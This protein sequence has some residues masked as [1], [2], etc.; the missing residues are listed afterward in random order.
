[1]DDSGYSLPRGPAH[2]TTSWDQMAQGPGGGGPESGSG[3]RHSENALTI[4]GSIPPPISSCAG[5]C[6]GNSVERKI[7]V[8]LNRTAPCVRLLNATH[9]I[10]CQCEW[11]QDCALR[12]VMV[13]CPTDS[14]APPLT[15]CAGGRM[16]SV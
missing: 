6:G 10:G 11:G 7:Y 3:G 13:L 8:T 14:S 9:Q 4:L 12:G 15:F 2:C 5:L 1:M 16:R